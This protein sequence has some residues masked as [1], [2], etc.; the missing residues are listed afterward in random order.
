MRASQVLLASSSADQGT[1]VLTRKSGNMIVVGTSVP[2][3]VRPGGNGVHSFGVCP[4]KDKSGVVAVSVRVDRGKH[5]CDWLD[6]ML[7]VSWKDDKPFVNLEDVWIPSAD[8]LGQVVEQH[9]NLCVEDQWFTTYEYG[10]ESQTRYLPDPNLACRYLVGDATAEDVIAAA[11]EAR[12][13]AS[14]RDQL[15]V[16]QQELIAAK[17]RIVE[18]EREFAGLK[19]GDKAT[20]KSEAGLHP[21]LRCPVC[22]YFV[23]ENV[24][25][26]WKRQPSDMGDE[27]EVESCVYCAED[28]R[29]PLAM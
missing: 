1:V 18:L 8:R 20:L 19:H 2:I 11:E 3:T 28:M 9:I 25:I 22:Q 24:D 13:E 26:R 23:V 17:Q 10:A 14:V 6:F 12:A 27:G 16:A 5:D 4:Q 21:L 29:R 7:P 15:Q